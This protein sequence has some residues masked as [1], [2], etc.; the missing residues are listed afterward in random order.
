MEELLVSTSA[1][2]DKVRSGH[3][4]TEVTTEGWYNALNTLSMVTSKDRRYRGETSANDAM[5]LYLQLMQHVL[6]SSRRSTS[7]FIRYRPNAVSGACN[8]YSTSG[9]GT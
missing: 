8:P 4:L 7:H 6:I 3:W 9:L 2:G 5:P 1:A